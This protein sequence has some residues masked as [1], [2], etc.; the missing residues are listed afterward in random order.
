METSPPLSG[1]AT[2]SWEGVMDFLFYT[3]V[4]ILLVETW[5]YFNT[6]MLKHSLLYLRLLLIF[7]TINV[8]NV[9]SKWIFFFLG[10]G[11][12][13]SWLKK[14][15]VKEIWPYQRVT[16]SNCDANPLYIPVFLITEARS[17][18][19]KK[20]N[21]SQS[22]IFSGGHLCFICTERPGVWVCSGPPLLSRFG[23]HPRGCPKR[24]VFDPDDLTEK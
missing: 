9:L 1:L 6:I 12:V 11:G 21:C 7:F 14:L 10:G 8:D 4:H 20:I 13:F 18:N 24:E 17:S 16:G 2:L 3:E 22:P 5:W 15:R 19:F 23:T